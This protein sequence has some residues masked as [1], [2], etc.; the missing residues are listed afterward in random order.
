M[1]IT[2]KVPALG[3]SLVDAVVGTWLKGEG[4][5]V[6]T[7]ETILELETDKVNLDVTADSDGVLSKIIAQEGDVVE[8]GA[9][10]A[11]IEPGAGAAASAPLNPRRLMILVR[12]NSPRLL[13]TLLRAEK[14][15]S[16]H[17]TASV[18]ATPV[19]QRL[20]ERAWH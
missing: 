17:E 18:R 16:G 8:V 3:E 6:S 12:R 20:A 4:D 9:D 14:Q 1:A 13:R 11:E 19:V 15:E 2:V 10:L 7:G 5:A